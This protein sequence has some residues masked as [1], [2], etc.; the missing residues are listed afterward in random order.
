MELGLGVMGLASRDY[1]AMTVLEFHAALDGWLEARGL[2]GRIS[3]PPLREE[4]EAMMA[5]FPD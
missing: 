5:R 1:W 2:R 4:L 3:A